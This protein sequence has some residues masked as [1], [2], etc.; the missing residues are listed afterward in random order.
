[1]KRLAQYLPALIDNTTEILRSA[2]IAAGGDVAILAALALGADA[3][4]R[5]EDM[6][7]LTDEIDRLRSERDDAVN[8][9]SDAD[10]CRDRATKKVDLLD[11]EIC[12]LRTDL[13]IARGR[14]TEL[15]LEVTSWASGE[16]EVVR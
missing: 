12:E 10:D 16:R 14:V 7:G 11:D 3:L 13:H 6:G 15:E 9:A 8:D 2:Q 5:V 4:A 1:M